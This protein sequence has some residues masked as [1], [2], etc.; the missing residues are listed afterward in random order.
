MRML[1][2]AVVAGLMITGCASTQAVGGASGRTSEATGAPGSASAGPATG[3]P[4]APPP[5]SPVDSRCPAQLDGGQHNAAYGKPVPD[6]IAVAWVLRCT[7]APQA[8][9]TRYLLV[10]R[11]DSD[12][13]GLLAALRTPDEPPS[14]GACPALAMVVPYFTLVKRDGGALVPHIPVTGC[15]L[16]QPPVL[17]ALNALQFTVIARHRL[18]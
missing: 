16:P 4:G 11:S 13:G 1:V 15:R 9:G 17:Q 6:G 10:E 5:V 2:A 14:S 7:V 8:G 18:P 12:P 3:R